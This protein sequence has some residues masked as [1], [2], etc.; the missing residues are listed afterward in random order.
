MKLFTT[1]QALL[2]LFTLSMV[3]LGVI[4]KPDYFSPA[5]KT[6]LYQPA[7]YQRA[8]LLGFFIAWLWLILCLSL[9]L[10]SR[11]AKVAAHR[12][13]DLQQIIAE[14][15]QNQVILLQE[16]DQMLQVKDQQ[17]EVLNSQLRD[18]DRL[19]LVDIVTGIPNQA[20]WERDVDTLSSTDDPS[21]CNQMIII[22]LDNFRLI[23]Q[24]YGYEKGD[25]VIRHFSRSIYNTMRRNEEIYKNF[26]LTEY[27]V[28]VAIEERWQ[29]IY[30]KYTGGDE[31][32]FIVNGSQPDALGFLNR[33]AKDLMPVINQRISQF[34]L[35][36]DTTLTFHAGMCE[37]ILGD[38]PN[39][40]LNRLHG[41][42]RKA[43][44]SSKSRLYLHPQLTADE[45]DDR[46][47]R[48]SG[49]KPRW[50]PYRDADVIFKKESLNI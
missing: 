16:R 42:L 44:N 8:S 49:A 13:N 33:V 14:I 21:P 43:S 15:K 48:S 31:F 20:K 9:F 18:R 37:W 23:N 34:I 24:K 36:E 19:R 32:I 5:L 4:N 17:I 29:R 41:C 35:E 50:N 46:I 45:Y 27:D 7:N 40:I 25:E 11:E 38:R 30:R 3:L 22:D 12:E 6:F 47:F 28:P 2:F 26:M 10:I 39:D 1:N